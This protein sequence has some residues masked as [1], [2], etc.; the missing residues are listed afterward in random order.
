MKG[1]ADVSQG[2]ACLAKQNYVF[3]TQHCVNRVATLNNSQTLEWKGSRS[4]R[5]VQDQRKKEEGRT[6]HHPLSSDLLM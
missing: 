2:R 3:Q 5:E 1:S 4:V 6:A